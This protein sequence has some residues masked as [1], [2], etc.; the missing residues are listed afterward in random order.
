MFF[1]AR[2]SLLV[3]ISLAIVVHGRSLS[4]DSNGSENDLSISPENST[5]RSTRS[6]LIGHGNGIIHKVIDIVLKHHQAPIFNSP[7]VGDD[8]DY[9]DRNPGSE[10][11]GRKNNKDLEV[12]SKINACFQN[13]DLCENIIPS[14]GRLGPLYN[15]GDCPRY[16]CRCE[17]EFFD[18]LKKID[19]MNSDEIGFRYFNVLRPKCYAIMPPMIGCAQFSRSNPPKCLLYEPGTEPGMKLQWADTEDWLE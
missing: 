8:D 18:C 13:H 6:L 19:S 17:R 5:R 10:G 2:T 15:D 12:S 16:S 1:V 3:C 7:P 4:E 9:P 11:N 14:G